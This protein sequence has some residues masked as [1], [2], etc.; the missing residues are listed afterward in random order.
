MDPDLLE[1]A[2]VK[3]EADAAS[4]PQSSNPEE[5]GLEEPSNALTSK[6]SDTFDVESTSKG[7]QPEAVE[8][9]FLGDRWAD[10]C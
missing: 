6:P 7:P 1:K 3:A 5:E 8:I 10:C 2:I 9:G 4:F